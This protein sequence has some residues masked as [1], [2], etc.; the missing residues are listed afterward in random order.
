MITVIITVAVYENAQG[1]W[2]CSTADF[3]EGLPLPEDIA[4]FINDYFKKK[5][6]QQCLMDFEVEFYNS[7]H[8]KLVNVR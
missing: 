2:V 4:D 7:G 8:V 5:P 1:D 6:V 3:K